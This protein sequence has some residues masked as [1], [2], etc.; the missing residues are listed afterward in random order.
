MTESLSDTGTGFRARRA[1]SVFSPLPILSPY[2]PQRLADHPTDDRPVRGLLAFISLLLFL[3]AFL[4]GFC[5]RVYG[6]A[7][8]SSS[9]AVRLAHF[10]LCP[11]S[12]SGVP[13]ILST[14]VDW[15]ANCQ[16]HFPSFLGSFVPA[17]V[18]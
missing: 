2:P 15:R 16:F 3:S 11:A 6:S 14:P 4:A 9:P 7:V 12:P 5:I 17:D 18:G 13:W 1:D 8:I 10:Q